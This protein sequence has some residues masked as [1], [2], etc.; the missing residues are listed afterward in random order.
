MARVGLVLGAGGAVGHAY[1]AGVLAALA[2][3]G[4]DPRSAEFIVGTSA[5]S[6][7]AAFLRAGM[8]GADLAA[9]SRRRPLSPAGAA[10]MARSGRRAR[11]DRPGAQHADVVRGP[12]AASLLL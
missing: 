2:E 3:T 5:G 9:S 10:L 1:H 12:A 7:V 4:W 11:L 8:S 6:I